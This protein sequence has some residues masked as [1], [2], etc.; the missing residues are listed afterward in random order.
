MGCCLHL[1]SAALAAS[2]SADLSSS[3][4]CTVVFNGVRVQA[5]SSTLLR[6]EP[7]GPTGYVDNSTFTVSSRS[8]FAGVPLRRTTSN[9]TH[10][11]L[12]TEFYSVEI[13]APPTP[14]VPTPAVPLPEAPGCFGRAGFAFQGSAGYP[15]RRISSCSEAAPSCL[16]PGATVE[17][18]CNNCTTAIECIAWE[19]SG[20]SCILLAETNSLRASKGY[21]SGGLLTP[22]MGANT[23]IAARVL[24]PSGQVLWSTDDLGAVSSQLS[25]PSP[26]NS[27]AYALK[28]F[29]RFHVPDWGAM[30]IPAE[31]ISK[32]DPATVISNGYDYRINTNGDCYVFLL[33]DTLDSWWASRREFLQLTGP[34]PALPDWAFGT[35]FTWWHQ[36]TEPEAKSEI[37]RWRTDQLPLDVWGLVRALKQTACMGPCLE[38]QALQSDRRCLLVGHELARH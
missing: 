27:T 37:E 25:W 11:S 15:P 17:E 2:I 20:G 32:V 31:E 12:A 4:S 28:D 23:G 7:V 13:T 24:S 36:Y 19:H 16:P 10:V 33:G 30:P 14:P 35:W 22:G 8:S 21:T 1:V 5:L 9:A 29:P 34:T 6:I 26:T 38:G 3:P 18:C